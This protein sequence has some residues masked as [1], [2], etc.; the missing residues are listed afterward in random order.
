MKSENAFD[1]HLAL[2]DRRFGDQDVVTHSPSLPEIKVAAIF[3]TDTLDL[4][5]AAADA[6][7]EDKSTPEAALAIYDLV[8][9]RIAFNQKK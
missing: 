4:C 8:I 2:L 6:V 1:R 3:V 5:K 9:A 7:F